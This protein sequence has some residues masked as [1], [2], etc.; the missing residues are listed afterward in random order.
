MLVYIAQRHKHEWI[1]AKKEMFH[2]L[3]ELLENALEKSP[4]VVWLFREEDGRV[5][6]I[7]CGRDAPPSAVYAD[8]DTAKMAVEMLRC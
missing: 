1:R 4:G 5:R 8:E 2:S 6:V 7:W 3:A